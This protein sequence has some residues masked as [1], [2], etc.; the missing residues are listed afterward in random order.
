M[1]AKSVSVQRSSPS[2]SQVLEGFRAAWQN[3]DV[4]ALTS[5][6]APRFQYLVNGKIAYTNKEE[7]QGFWF[8]N[9]IDQKDLTVE[10]FNQSYGRG[11]AKTFLGA[12]FY[13]PRRCRI[14]SV[15]GHIEITLDAAGKISRL[16]QQSVTI[17]RRSFIYGVAYIKR[18][19]LDPVSATARRM[20]R[21][22]W[23]SIGTIV[24]L[25]LYAVM[26]A[27]VLLVLYG[28]ILHDSLGWVSDNTATFLK[29][30]TP[31]WFALA[32]ILQQTI[33]VIKK[34]VIHDVHFVPIDGEADLALMRKFIDGADRVEIVSGDF[35]F[36]DTDAELQS[37]LKELAYAKKLNLVSYKAEKKVKSEVKGKSIGRDILYKLEA[38]KAV[39]YD[40]P[41]HAKVTIVTHGRNRKMLF[42]Y[43]RDDNG[44]QRRYMGVVRETPNTGA[45]L[46]L[47]T[48]IIEQTKTPA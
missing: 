10:F 46:D 14:V 47:I 40:F 16:S 17:E 1:T 31:F 45:L 24:Q 9:A 7:L 12:Y 2:P 27:G 3:H 11:L 48:R 5:L 23:R 30:Y 6:F 35:S 41:V 13:T 34:K 42:R 38:D 18:R 36:L 32:Y 8:R 29:R 33:L 19:L 22:I 43:W 26:W 20:L 39:Q 15:S 25:I 37:R 21:P 4:R 44:E 28:E